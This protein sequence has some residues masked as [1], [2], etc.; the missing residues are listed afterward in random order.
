MGIVEENPGG[1]QAV[2][3]RRPGLRM[4]AQAPHPVVEVVHGNEKHVGFFRPCEGA[5]ERQKPCESDHS[6]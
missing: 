6:E 5:N 1:S 3:V 4:T 2:E